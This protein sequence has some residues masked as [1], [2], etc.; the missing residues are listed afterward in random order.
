MTPLLQQAF[1]VLAALPSVEQDEMAARLLD[2]LAAEDAFDLALSATA[3]RL[4]GISAEA[5]AEYRAGE[6]EPLDPET[7]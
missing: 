6:T 7:L 2:E 4:A 3:E 1:T 5:L